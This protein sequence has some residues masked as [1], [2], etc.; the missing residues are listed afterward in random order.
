MYIF[1]K[2]TLLEG[3]PAAAD[4]QGPGL[5]RQRG[6]GDLYRYSHEDHQVGGSAT[7]NGA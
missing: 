5:L 1:D 4:G 3:N 6:E 7:R 2:N